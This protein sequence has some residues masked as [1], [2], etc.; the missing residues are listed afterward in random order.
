MRAMVIGLVVVSLASGLLGCEQ[1][2]AHAPTLAALQTGDGAKRSGKWLMQ[3]EEGM[4]RLD[5]NPVQSDTLDVV[6]HGYESRGYEWV[7]ALKRFGEL[8][9]EVVFYRWDWKVCPEEGAKRLREKL[10]ALVAGRPGAKLVRV[11]GHSYGGV[12]TALMAQQ[13]SLSLP[14]EVHVIAAP[15][16]GMGKMKTLCGFSGVGPAQADA[17]IRWFQWRTQHQLDGAFRDLPTDPQ[18]V[19]LG[20]GKVETLPD[21][22][23]GRRLG[24]NWS[25]SWVADQVSPQSAPPVP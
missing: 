13:G 4:T 7:Y 19:M 16:A 6:V 9:H 18:V 22:Y 2:P 12:I 5:S 21:T 24:H 11:F 20:V 14:M 10:E 1:I 23:R 8:G 3:L 25:V 17:K 15:L